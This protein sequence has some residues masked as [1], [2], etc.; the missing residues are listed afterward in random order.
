MSRVSITQ[1]EGEQQQTI[2]DYYIFQSR[3]YD[4][5]RWAFLFGRRSL[6]RHLP[7]A[8]DDSF[9]LIEVGCGT[10]YNLKRLAKMYP[11]A[12]LTGL[13]LSSHML[14]IAQ[15]NLKSY[16]PRVSLRK[17]AYG[18][19]PSAFHPQVIIFSYA[20]SMINPQWEQLLQQAQQDLAPQGIIAVVD[21]H[22][23]AVSQFK[24]HMSNHH[25]RMDAHLLPVLRKRFEVIE[26]KVAPAYGG[27]WHYF[28]YI[29]RKK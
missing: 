29:G 18:E 3:I 2:A 14:A 5:T 6:I 11:N 17:K 20:L 24:A 22:N 21:F 16:G 10:G 19:N 13:D 15:N 9:S 25:V 1:T 28:S 26:E 27:L 8:K 12:K 4:F 7:M 23:S